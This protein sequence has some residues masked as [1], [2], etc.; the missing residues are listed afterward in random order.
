MFGKCA[1]EWNKIAQFI[2][3]IFCQFLSNQTKWH[4]HPKRAS[5]LIYFLT[6]I[7]LLRSTSH[8]VCFEHDTW[9][10][11]CMI[12]LKQLD[13]HLLYILF[14]PSARKPNFSLIVTPIQN[15]HCILLMWC[16]YYWFLDVFYSMTLQF[17]R[18][19]NP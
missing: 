7:M 4:D 12:E 19:Y 13:E 6:S 2:P 8:T 16:I 11:C 15:K 14:C 1:Q 10:I 18:Q 5:L 9:Y 3:I 17:L